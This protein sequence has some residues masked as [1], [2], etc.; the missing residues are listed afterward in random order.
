M[1][2]FLFGIDK[3]FDQLDIEERP[4]TYFPHRTKISFS[5]NFGKDV[6]VE[7]NNIQIKIDL[8]LEYKGVIGVF[9]GKN[10]K[11]A[12]FAIYQIYHPFLYY[13][14]A[15]EISEIKGKIK[16]IYGVYVVKSMENKIT[17]INIWAYTFEKPLDIA[18]IKFIKSCSYRLINK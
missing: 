17:T 16:K 13:H 2:H 4:K 7:L 12:S 14:K 15:N 10:G 18:S 1:H 6:I 3:E 11:P 8:T 5:Y 9:E